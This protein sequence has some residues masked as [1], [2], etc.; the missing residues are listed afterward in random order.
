MK[1]YLI[2][3]STMDQCKLYRYNM[4]SYKSS[5]SLM[6]SLKLEIIFKFQIIQINPEYTQKVVDVF[7][8]TEK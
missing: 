1:K 4:G 6:F 3:V 8:C 5:M 2:S 7:F